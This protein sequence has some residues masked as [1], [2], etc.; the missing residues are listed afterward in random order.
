MA[1]YSF[2]AVQEY[3]ESGLEHDHWF[4][5]SFCDHFDDDSDDDQEDL[6]RVSKGKTK[7]KKGKKAVKK[8]KKDQRVWLDWDESEKVHTYDLYPAEVKYAARFRDGLTDDRSCFYHPRWFQEYQ[9]HSN[10]VFNYMWG[11][12]SPVSLAAGAGTDAYG[13]R[14][15]VHAAPPKEAD[16]T[17]ERDCDDESSDSASENDSV[18]SPLLCATVQYNLSRLSYQIH[19]CEGGGSQ[20]WMRTKVF[21][22]LETE[23]NKLP[24]VWSSS[25]ASVH[26]QTVWVDSLRVVLLGITQHWLW[27]GG[28]CK[29]Y[30]LEDLEYLYDV[31]AR[32]K[33]ALSHLVKD[34]VFDT[35][36]MYPLLRSMVGLM[37]GIHE[38]VA[39]LFDMC[40]DGRYWTGG[41]GGVSAKQPVFEGCVK[42]YRP[43]AEGY[44]LKYR[45]GGAEADVHAVGTASSA[46]ASPSNT[47]VNIS[48]VTMDSENN[49][50]VLDDSVAPGEPVSKK[51]K[52]DLPG[53]ILPK[54]WLAA[55]PPGSGA[56][57]FSAAEL[58]GFRADLVEKS[59]AII[60]QSHHTD[61]K[62]VTSAEL[63]VPV[64]SFA[65][66][67]QIMAGASESGFVGKLVK[68]SS[69][70]L[71][72]RLDNTL[73]NMADNRRNHTGDLQQMCPGFPVIVKQ[74]AD[75]STL[76]SMRE[77]DSAEKE[78][79]YRWTDVL[80]AG[81]TLVIFH[82]KM[83]IVF[84][85]HA[86][87]Y[88]DPRKIADCDYI[89]LCGDSSS[90][91]GKPGTVCPYGS[92]LY[93]E[94]FQRY[95]MLCRGDPHF[96][97]IPGHR[98][99][100]FN[101]RKEEV[102]GRGG[103]RLATGKRVG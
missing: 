69:K 72:F 84:R 55:T 50:D 53:D 77:D 60:R 95:A 24:A 90:S 58:A 83:R 23:V 57:L 93:P 3:V 45:K 19:N 82:D 7:I 13:C 98:G 15:G 10:V 73:G 27:I 99:Y 71:T 64:P 37:A 41:G 21:G 75:S 9:K 30:G 14:N 34:G 49:N 88:N 51:R 92:V 8:K 22:L 52:V 65:V 61:H 20:A 25:H 28:D 2:K 103:K 67:R 11:L 46:G 38:D 18:P 101:K 97:Y 36:A 16:E 96:R 89:S 102:L 43:I 48:T 87:D 39:A 100:L 35:A 81:A 78:Y 80:V 91:S 56:T 44:V 29:F 40:R 32:V 1:T 66:A 47:A 31:E 59:I 85:S 26:K 12:E 74:C 63:V 76:V 70:T 68:S 79:H 33:I 54:A 6:L 4:V 94:V 17:S 62:T 42:K 86:P 5:E